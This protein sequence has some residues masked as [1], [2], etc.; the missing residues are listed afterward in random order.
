MVL[1]VGDQCM[2]SILDVKAKQFPKK[3]EAISWN[4]F[5]DSVAA[6]IK[7]AE[8]FVEGIATWSLTLDFKSKYEAWSGMETRMHAFRGKL[9]RY[10]KTFGDYEGELKSQTAAAN[11]E[12]TGARDKLSLALRNVSVAAPVAKVV[13][14]SVMSKLLPTHALAK[15]QLPMAPVPDNS[16]VYGVFSS[17]QLLP[18]LE[19]N[20]KNEFQLQAS[21][22]YDKM[23]ATWSASAAPKVTAC[24]EAGKNSW[25]GTVGD[26]D[27]VSEFPW[28][29]CGDLFKNMAGAKPIMFVTR[30]GVCNTCR[31]VAPLQ[32]QRL[33]IQ[34]VQGMLFVVVVDG[35]FRT[36]IAI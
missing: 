20:G 28:S 3:A 5:R 25:H 34:I 2:H 23:A 16:D 19:S 18:H 12:F 36:P 21:A 13:A 7:N 6:Q 9:L 26:N 10:Q 17:V 1:E 33:A 15:V 14:E 32:Q 22:Y 11:S 27:A 35:V 8:T 30:T 29:A 31:E 24:V 4:E